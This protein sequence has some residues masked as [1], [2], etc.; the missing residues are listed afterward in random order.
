MASG[1][2][3][4]AEI[5]RALA[6][7]VDP[8]D[9]VELRALDVSTSRYARLYTVSGYFTDLGKLEEAA[10]RVQHAKGIYI[11]LNL[12]HPDLLARAANRLRPAERN[13]STGDDHI[14]RRRW[15]PIDCDPVRPSGICATDAEHEAA[16]TR[17]Y[18]IRDVLREAGWPDPMTADGGNSGHLL[19]AIDLPNDA[20]SRALL[21]RC[22]EA[23]AFRC[24]D[25]RVV[26][27]TSVFNAARIWRL[28]GTMNRKG[29]DI[30]NRPHRLTRLLTVP[31]RI[32]PV[33]REL[34]EALARSARQ[35][36]EPRLV[37][38]A[39][40]GQPFEIE[41]WIA[42]HGLD[43]SGPCPWGKGRKWIFPVC[44]WNTDH[45]NRSAYIVENVS[46]AIAAGCHHNGCHGKDWPALRDLVEP[47]WQEPRGT[48]HGGH[49][50]ERSAG[51]DNPW[52]YIKDAPTF[53]AEPQPEFEGLAKE[54]LAPG[55]ITMLAAPRG[56]GKMQVA[57][58]LAVALATAGVFRGE[59]VKGVRVLLL[60]R[61]N[62]EYI[63]RQ[64]LQA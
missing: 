53:L 59:R 13:L 29:D 10:A 58:S 23:L 38:R 9:V 21:Q 60:D 42:T 37:G 17:A 36:E 8:G 39:G 22:L 14:L 24:D 12:V 44:P 52:E 18:E 26:V 43:V 27:D 2:Y 7:L 30:P 28:Y 32:T 5:R 20:D 40:N 34:L 4:R 6:Q 46:G 50:Q 19:Y 33:P 55:A 62:P 11:T 16:L 31:E 61:D 48:P 35:P 15:F 41:Q 51:E 45:R 49:V 56:L 63:I 47:G 1:S 64:R 54:L 3:D 57:H 25:E